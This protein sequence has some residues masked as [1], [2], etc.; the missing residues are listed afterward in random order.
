VAL[1]GLYWAMIGLFGL[2]F[3]DIIGRHFGVPKIMRDLVITILSVAIMLT[4]LGRAG[5]NLVGIVAT[6]AVVTAVVGLALQDTLG[7]LISGIALQVESTI[8]IGD[9]IRVDEKAIG[10]VREIRWRSTV[11]QT[12][13]GDLVTIPNGL[14]SKGVITQ[15]NKDGLENRRWVYFNVHL[16][17]PPN[18]VQEVVV[19]ALQGTPN[20]STATPA[21]CIV[22][23][24]EESYLKYAVRYRLIDFLPDDP[25]DSE[26]RKRI[27]YA[28]NRNEIEI[29]YTSHNVFL[30]ENTQARKQ[31]RVERE[32]E[33]RLDLLEQVAIFAPLSKDDRLHVADGM[34]H[35]IFGRG[36]TVMRVGEPGESLY[37]LRAGEVSVRLVA[38]GLEKEVAQLKDGDFFGEMSFM[39]GE[40]RSATIVAVKDAECY[41]IDST[42]MT[43]ILHDNATLAGEIGRLLSQREMK[44]KI[45]L[46][47]LSAEAASRHADHERLLERIK[48]FFGLA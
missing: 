26:V 9:W 24:Y 47:G 45:E 22:W 3:F 23:S 5:V 12:K 35:T 46:E 7:N 15:F 42:A 32:R 43:K 44:N 4:L 37:V 20:V 14:F 10:K 34:H 16:R 19:A 36:E 11:I 17:H 39:T 1:I 31:S 18:H 8:S 38:D 28:L 30:T 29:P 2:F 6:S 13:N 33:R 27:W 48:S 40:P 41:V 25:T 21:D